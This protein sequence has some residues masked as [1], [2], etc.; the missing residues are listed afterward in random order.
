MLVELLMLNDEVIK[1]GMNDCD[2]LKLMESPLIL[3]M[4][5]VTVMYC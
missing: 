2:L 5:M 4:V 3:V 1:I